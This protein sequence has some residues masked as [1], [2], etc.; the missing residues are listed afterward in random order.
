MSSNPSPPDERAPP[1]KRGRPRKTDAQQA[2][3]RQEIADTA[4]RLFR[5]EGYH[6]VSMRR[7]AK[8]MNVTPM[9]LYSYFPSKLAILSCLW[10]DILE[11]VRGEMTQAAAGAQTPRACLLAL[12]QAYVSYWLQRH[13]Y[14]HLVFMSAGLTQADVTE[15]VAEGSAVSKLELFFEAI[16]AITASDRKDEQVK[17][18]ADQLICCLHGVMH[19]IITVPGYPWT[20]TNVLVKNI[21][22]DI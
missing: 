19:C 3:V 10:I 2:A 6:A 12:S 22:R 18:K 5:S 21:V 16:A 17:Q 20:D 14:Y 9:A 8:E 11:E 7:L 4:S 1:Q 15:F 13:D